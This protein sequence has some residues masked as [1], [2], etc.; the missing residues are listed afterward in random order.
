MGLADD[1]AFFQ[2]CIRNAPRIVA[3]HLVLAGPRHLVHPNDNF[4]WIGLGGEPRV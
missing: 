4:T 2:G 1:R 3:L